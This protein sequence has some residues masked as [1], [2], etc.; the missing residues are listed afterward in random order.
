MNI[1]VSSPSFS[2]SEV[3]VSE[4]RAIFPQLQL[5]SDAKEWERNTLID[6]LSDA[7]A[8]II[9]RERVDEALLANL[10]RLRCIAKYGVGLDNIDIATVKKRGIYLGTSSGVNRRS[11]AEL[12]LCF[13]LGL[14]RNIFFSAEQVKQG[15]WNKAGGQQ[16]SAKKVGVIGCGHTGSEL[17]QLLLPFDCE[18]Y[19]N[20]IID[21]S[22]FIQK[23][24]AKGQKIASSLKEGIY[25]DCDFISLHV[26]LTSQTRN[27]IN[28][29]TL[30]Q[31]QSHSYLVNT[32]R[33]EIIDEN[34]LYA[35]LEQ[36]QIAGAALDVFTQEPLPAD[37]K[38][39]TLP[40]IVCTPHIGG[41]AR[42]AILS[43]GRVAIKHL[44]EWSMNFPCSTHF[45]SR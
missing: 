19:V 6:F 28:A 34:A 36:K 10:P 33:G 38:L 30:E 11:V 44:H 15:Q 26:P 3:L 45:L 23:Q 2:R 1:C 35:T 29:T 41:N 18:I 16:L 27:I 40:N 43:M 9:G 17:V 25:R 8:A 37:N 5:N 7:D 24:E 12:A 32:S 42:E 4:L 22:A 21:K 39:L 13:L 14:A 20:D 31:M